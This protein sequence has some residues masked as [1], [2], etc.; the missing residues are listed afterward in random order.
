MIV[1][2]PVL[3]TVPDVVTDKDPLAVIVFRVT[4]VADCTVMLFAVKFKAPAK[5]LA[6]FDR[7]TS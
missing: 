3:K 5:K 6:A 2:T 7:V 1:N 4:R